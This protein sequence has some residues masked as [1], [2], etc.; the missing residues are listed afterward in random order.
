ML[1][2][3]TLQRI[4]AASVETKPLEEGEIRRL[5]GMGGH[6][7]CREDVSLSDEYGVLVTFSF[8]G[9]RIMLVRRIS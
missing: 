2:T 9:N 1:L 5:E 8:D 6:F 4:I 3:S 7:V